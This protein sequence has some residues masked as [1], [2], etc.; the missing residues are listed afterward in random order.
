MNESKD[1][2]TVKLT[3]IGKPNKLYLHLARDVHWQRKW[4]TMFSL[5][6]DPRYIIAAF[7]FA[8][9]YHTMTCNHDHCDRDDIPIIFCK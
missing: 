9:S 2:S 6:V 8:S 1:E 5:S 4:T 7:L 3:I